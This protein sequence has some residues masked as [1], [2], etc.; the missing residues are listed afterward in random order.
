[1]YGII[2]T[3][4]LPYM[5]IYYVTLHLQQIFNTLDTNDDKYS[6]E[7]VKHVLID[8][9][10]RQLYSSICAADIQYCNSISRAAG[11]CR[12]VLMFKQWC[13]S[14]N[15]TNRKYIFSR[16]DEFSMA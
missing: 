15:W 9:T 6:Y 11:T 2:S 14:H 13:C 12:Q 5:V 8:T 10:L 4:S 1:M 16:E 3:G 7:V